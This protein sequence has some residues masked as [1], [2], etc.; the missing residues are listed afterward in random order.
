MWMSLKSVTIVLFYTI[1]AIYT[2]RWPSRLFADEIRD[3]SDYQ[4]YRNT[5]H[6]E[7]KIDEPEI[8]SCS[9]SIVDQM[10]IV[11]PWC[12]LKPTEIVALPLVASGVWSY[13]DD[14]IWGYQF[15]Q[16]EFVYTGAKI[17]WKQI[18]LQYYQ[19]YDL[20]KSLK[21][22]VGFSSHIPSLWSFPAQ[23]PRTIASMIQINDEDQVHLQRLQS[24][25]VRLRIPLLT[26]YRIQMESYY[27]AV[28]ERNLRNYGRCSK[29]NYI[30][31]RSALH[32][33]YLLPW[34]SF[35]INPLLAGLD[36]Y[37][38]WATPWQYLFYAGVCGVSTQLF[39]TSLLMPWLVS[40]V[41]H[42]H[43]EWHTKYYGQ[44]VVWDDAAILDYR[45]QFTIQNQHS[46]PLLIK[47]RAKW[48]SHYLVGIT[49]N[50]HPI[51]TISKKEIS[52]L[53]WQVQKTVFA[54]WQIIQTGEW[55]TT[56]L[57]KNHEQ[58]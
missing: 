4:S 44:K 27:F 38:E 35:T 57:R 49:Q 13:I 43:N 7:T 5:T 45:K 22:D 1:C 58:N 21:F 41:R 29:H 6:T 36:G 52:P 3:R 53:Q 10:A 51:V 28:V 33:L 31:A 18:P 47:W 26:R 30:M 9:G 14:F 19:T 40:T 16:E 48:D 17:V 20:P 46:N 25:G 24:A 8:W 55:T 11:E 56:Y 37:C 50:I 54:S 34:Q 2:C 15:D 42:G 32:D 12:L 23:N 39:R